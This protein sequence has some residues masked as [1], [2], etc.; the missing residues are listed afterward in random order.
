MPRMDVDSQEL[1]AT[2]EALHKGIYMCMKC[3]TKLG[4]PIERVQPKWNPARGQGPMDRW[5]M[6]IGQ[7]PGRVEHVH[8]KVA[9][10][11][12]EASGNNVAFSGAA[13]KNLLRWLT[14]SG[15]FTEEE[16]KRNFWKT[17][18]TKCYPGP[19]KGRGDRKPTKR[20]IQ[21]CEH[22]LLSEIKLVRPTMIVPLGLAAIKWFFPDVSRLSDAVGKEERQW[23]YQGERYAVI[24]LP[25]PSGVNP[26]LNDPN[27]KV[28][29]QKA[30]RKIFHH[31]RAES[32]L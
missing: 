16:V 20:E 10:A 13:G 21:Y 24:C 18:V 2:R 25:H 8:G 28:L 32:S 6:L 17:A 1:Y 12:T 9:T 31:W 19:A 5:G 29:H 27:H 3:K 15:G 26:W 30:L 7:A 11:T 22:F 23:L 4:K 14:Q